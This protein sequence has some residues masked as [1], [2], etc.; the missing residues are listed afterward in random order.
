MLGRGPAPKRDSSAELIGID[1]VYLTVSDFARSRRFYDRLMKALGF[2]EGNR[3]NRW[4][5]PLPLLQS[6]FP[7]LHTSGA[8][9]RN[10]T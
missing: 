2:K 4:R 7:G 5:T 9:S 6:Q 3:S 8:P 1:H 10:Q